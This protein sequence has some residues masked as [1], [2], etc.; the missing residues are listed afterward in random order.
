VSVALLRDGS[1][2]SWGTYRDAGGLL[3]FS[4][5]ADVQREP[6]L[7]ENLP[8][9]RLVVCGANHS[10]VTMRTNPSPSPSPDP[11]PQP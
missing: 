1:V 6:L 9:V 4:E 7:L 8:T 3:G 11:S 10:L 2:A 5:A